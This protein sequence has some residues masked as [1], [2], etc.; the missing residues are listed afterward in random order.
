MFFLVS[1]LV[2]APGYTE[3]WSRKGRGEAY[4]F[5]QYMSGDDTT[6][7]G[8]DLK[9]DAIGSGGFGFGYNLNDYL[10]LNTEFYFGATDISVSSGTASVDGDSTV[11]GMNFNLDYNILKGR[12]TPVV[13]GGIGFMNFNGDFE[14]Y[15]FDETDF[16]YNVGGGLRW[17]MGEHW[18]LKAIYRATW[19]KLQDTDDTLMFNGASFMVGYVF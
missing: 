5:G 9:V 13:T 16:S 6:G 15:S 12:I 2:V 17:D 10:N 4:L 7:M 3:D 1:L 19:T 14:G 18:F 8:L 11:I